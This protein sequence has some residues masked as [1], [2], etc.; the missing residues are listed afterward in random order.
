M[1][2]NSMQTQMFDVESF[3]LVGGESSRMGSDKSRLP[4]GGRS[5]VEMVAQA[6]RPVSA[7]VRLVGSKTSD[8]S[9]F[10]RI[11]DLHPSWGPIAGI[12]AALQAATS[13]WS[14]IV[15]CDLPFVTSELFE[16]LLSQAEKAD[17]VV[18]I[19]NDLRPQPL[20]AI[21]R[22]V[23]C[24]TAAQAAID[25]GKHAPRALLDAVNTH[26]I[27]F[28]E[29]SDLNGAEYFFFN[30]NTPENYK[31]AKEIARLKLV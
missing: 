26:Y 7:R 13:D 11:P 18:P 1:K 3:I 25:A 10:E 17:A 28:E 8:E 29:L 4:L 27:Q 23:P 14:I 2:K 5:S 30:V 19:Q 21:Y 16:R 24:L 9:L 22:R 15:A 12:E 31:Q 6:L 20:C